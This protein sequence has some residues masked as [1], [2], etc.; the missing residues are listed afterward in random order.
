MSAI[1]VVLLIVVVVVIAAAVLFAVRLARQGQR[2]Y[3]R[4]HDLVP[5]ERTS[6]PAAWGGAHTPEA[7]LHRRL[8]AA[9]DALDALPDDALGGEW[10]TVAEARV[11]IVEQAR[12]LDQ[13]LITAASLPERTR[14][15]AVATIE[16]AVVALEDAVTAVA[17]AATGDPAALARAVA[18]IT[19]RVQGLA[20]AREEL[21]RLEHGAS[22]EADH[23][24]D[25]APGASPA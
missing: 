15:D 5:G 18:E 4:Q 6:A 21:E 14:A 10:A 13:R 25:Q 12:A 7:R 20:A 19:T 17:T 11:T 1:A 24:G 3:Q 22:P 16:P 8:G 9:L 23:P 2:R